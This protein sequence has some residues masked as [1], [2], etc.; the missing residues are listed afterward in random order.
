MNE[1]CFII[2]SAKN[3]AFWPSFGADSSGEFLLAVLSKHSE[4][5]TD[6]PA[7]AG[8]FLYSGAG[9][10]P[11]L[12][13]DGG[14]LLWRASAWG[15]G[16][17]ILPL[18]PFMCGFASGEEVLRPDHVR[19][20][21]EGGAELLITVAEYALTEELLNAAARTRA[22]ENR[23]F[24]LLVIPGRPPAVFDPEGEKISPLRGLRGEEYVLR[25]AGLQLR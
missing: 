7:D 15:D 1:P 13:D 24:S 14:N 5:D 17:S 23:I 11:F 21:A 10:T 16:P 4:E 18:G 20:L 25:K 9:R 19:R 2:L 22:A 8:A 12:K 6:L 3:P